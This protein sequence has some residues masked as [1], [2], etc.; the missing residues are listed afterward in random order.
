MTKQKN[1]GQ[2][3]ILVALLVFIAILSV[4]GVYF[5]Q[6][7][8]N[9]Q[10]TPPGPKNTGDL[11]EEEF[12]D[13]GR[14]KAILDETDLW[15]IY[16]D[17][18]AGFSVKYP[19]NVSLAASDTTADLRLTVEATKIDNLDSPMYSQAAALNNQAA[20]AL[21]QYGQDVD[22]PLN[23]SKKVASLDNGIN[24]QEFMVLGRFEVCDVVFER[25]LLFFN[26]DSQIV[27]TLRG[28]QAKIVA[29][30]P[31]FFRTDPQN[32]FEEKIWDFD[33]QAEFYQQLSAGQAPA[34]AQEWFDA[35]DQI[36]KTIKIN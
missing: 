27:I 13:S 23:T 5:W 28:P 14:A 18:A 10:K 22:W 32:C 33:R 20:L 7:Y 1:K 17:A 19:A 16:E 12:N 2:V 26:H 9:S 35:F 34:D 29:A 30:M 31:E 25:R 21:G 3:G 11:S 8:E 36:V 24:A 6:K 4:G 15:P